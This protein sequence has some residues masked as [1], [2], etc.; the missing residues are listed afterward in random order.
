[1]LDVAKSDPGA[2]TQADRGYQ[3]STGRD[4]YALS[5]ATLTVERTTTN[6]RGSG[7]TQTVKVV[8]KKSS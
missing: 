7:G 3:T 4:V 6:A 5:G 8:Y 1:M 2:A